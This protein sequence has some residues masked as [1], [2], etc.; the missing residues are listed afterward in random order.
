M[1]YISKQSNLEEMAKFLETYSPLR[2]NQEE[3]EN[4]NKPIMRKF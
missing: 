4:Q 2:M 1:N 3:I